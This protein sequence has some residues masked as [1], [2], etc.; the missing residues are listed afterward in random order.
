MVIVKSRAFADQLMQDFNGRQLEGTVR[1]LPCD[2]FRFKITGRGQPADSSLIQFLEMEDDHPLR[3]LL[4]AILS[5]EPSADGLLPA[6]EA[7]EL[8]RDLYTSD[9]ELWLQAFYKTDVS[10]IELEGIRMIEEAPENRVAG[11]FDTAVGKVFALAGLSAGN[12][13]EF[14][15]AQKTVQ[16][17]LMAL[18]WAKKQLLRVDWRQRINERLWQLMTSGELERDSRVHYE[19]VHLLFKAADGM[20][21]AC[22][23]YDPSEAEQQIEELGHVLECC[24]D[25]DLNRPITIARAVHQQDQL[26]VDSPHSENYEEL[27]VQR[28]LQLTNA[29]QCCRGYWRT[30]TLLGAWE[31]A[32][33]DLQMDTSRVLNAREHSQKALPQL[34]LE[35][36]Q[37]EREF[38]VY[39]KSR[40]RKSGTQNYMGKLRDQMQPPMHCERTLEVGLRNFLDYERSTG[41]VAVLQRIMECVN[42]FYEEVRPGSVE[43]VEII[44]QLAAVANGHLAADDLSGLEIVFIT[45]EGNLRADDVEPSALAIF[46]LSLLF[47]KMKLNNVRL[48]TA[49]GVEHLDGDIWQRILYLFLCHNFQVVQSQSLAAQE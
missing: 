23:T 32:A 36:L 10:L 37:L 48:L 29:R 44:C 47:A 17:V 1:I 7:R 39:P 28:K 42:Q 19:Q 15:Y 13:T 30:H 41:K 31:G 25:I 40:E 26:Y 27:L 9:T 33:R 11:Q 20:V 22:P 35:L 5:T 49:V 24:Q 45:P 43:R 16:D 14:L 4:S 38:N 12:A 46:G 6:E 34:E 2:Y 18:Y 21:T 3:S 8:G